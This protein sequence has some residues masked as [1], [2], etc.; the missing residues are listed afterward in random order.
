MI[1]EANNGSKK[2]EYLKFEENIS[3]IRQPLSIVNP[4]YK[5][6]VLVSIKILILGGPMD[7][8]F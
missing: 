2:D 7:S 3:I 6:L 8:L 5:T 4:I 1:L